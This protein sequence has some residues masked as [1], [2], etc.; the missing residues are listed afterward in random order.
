VTGL[1]DGL[2]D[3]DKTVTITVSSN[4]TL[5][6][7]TDVSYDNDLLVA[8]N[9]IDVFDVDSPGII[10]VQDATSI[11]E[12]EGSASF[13]IY[14]NNSPD[15]SD[16]VIV[17]FTNA[18]GNLVSNPAF[19]TFTSEN[20]ASIQNILVTSSS[21]V[22]A[23]ET[24][25]IVASVSSGNYGASAE[26]LTYT[27]LDGGTAQFSVLADDLQTSEDGDTATFDVSLVF[28]PTSDVTVNV[29]TS[30]SNEVDISNATLTFTS[31]NY[32]T[33]QIV[34]LTGADDSDL[35]G[36]ADYTITLTGVQAGGSSEY[37]GVTS[38]IDYTNVD[39]DTPSIQ[40]VYDTDL[41][42]AEWGSSETIRL[43]LGSTPGSTVSVNVSVSDNLEASI[44]SS[45]LL[46][47]TSNG[48]E[49]TVTVTGLDD[50]VQD[51]HKNFD[52]IFDTLI[53]NDED[54]DGL[55]VPDL[56]FLNIDDET[57]GIVVIENSTEQTPNDVS[58]FVQEISD[59]TSTDT[60]QVQLITAPS[61]NVVFN[62]STSDATEGTVSPSQ[63]IL[64][65]TSASSTITLTGVD[66]DIVDGSEVFSVDLDIDA[67]T[68]DPNFF[69]FP[70][71]N[72]EAVNESFG[73]EITDSANLSI[74]GG[75]YLFDLLTDGN[76]LT[77]TAEKGLAPFEWVIASDAYDNLSFTNLNSDNSQI[78]LVIGSVTDSYRISVTD[79]RVS[80]DNTTSYV[81]YVQGSP[82]ISSINRP[83]PTTLQLF[84]SDILE[85]STSRFYNV[86]YSEDGINFTKINSSVL[87]SETVSASSKPTTLDSLMLTVDYDGSSAGFFSIVAVDSSGD[88][89]PSI[90]TDILTDETLNVKYEVQAADDQSVAD[91]FG[92]SGSG[93]GGGGCLL[94]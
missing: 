39:N 31:S 24:D 69:G 51:G 72:L 81:M 19:V 26:T 56:T 94:K 15:V 48:F 53:S 80:S 8:T 6:E 27:V 91:T 85:T 55:T 62:I 90:S 58:L 37:A 3:G 77:L 10:V 64:T 60:F 35:D 14:L 70:Q 46:F 34:T 84:F 57:S 36:L 2:S 73:L 43:V 50:S 22:T 75:E 44:D 88:E 28:Q 23:N 16:N 12:N 59:G 89:A 9:S 93:G 52:L 83:T 7:T 30:D 32:D 65:S 5:S 47:S 25:T 86:Y 67:S 63:I 41:N 11:L 18:T 4:S 79:S 29:T 45:I 78:Q 76:T 82:F 38:S 54:Y 49:N 40:L 33:V 1:D 87:T 92:G 66:D 42:T 61:G 21:L 20:F 17:S 68:T 13:Q 71:I 74:E